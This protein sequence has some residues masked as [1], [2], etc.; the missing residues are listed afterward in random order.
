[1]K[2]R[3]SSHQEKCV[4]KEHKISIH[5]YIRYVI[6]KRQNGFSVYNRIHRYFSP[7]H[8]SINYFAPDFT[9]IYKPHIYALWIH[10]NGIPDN[11]IPKKK[12]NIPYSLFFS[13]VI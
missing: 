1:M 9:I 12:H 5:P 6:S 4:K 11:G 2:L 7:L 8:Y 10:Y 3:T 13:I